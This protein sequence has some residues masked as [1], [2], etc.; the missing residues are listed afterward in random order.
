MT[1]IRSM[2]SSMVSLVSQRTP[3]K[4]GLYR[5]RPSMSTR[6]LLAEKALK[7]RL[8]TAHLLASIRATCRP[9]TMRNTSGRVVAP[10]RFMSS[11]LITKTAAAASLAFSAFLETEVIST[12][13]SSSRESSVILGCAAQQGWLPAIRMEIA[14]RLVA[15][16]RDRSRFLLR[17]ER[18]T[19]MAKPLFFCPAAMYV[20]TIYFYSF[21]A[22]LA[23]TRRI[24]GAKGCAVACNG[25]G[26]CL[27]TEK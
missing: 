6:S 10:E 8:V 11:W 9:G 1:S 3:E 24:I 17:S 27:K 14:A 5:V 7:P 2:S 4:S 13:S 16:L 15:V 18:V 12:E 21:P 26:C 22:T 25:T 19:A 23:S 20:E